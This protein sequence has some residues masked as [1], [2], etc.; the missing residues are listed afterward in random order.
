MSSLR[1]FVS[2]CQG[3]HNSNQIKYSPADFSNFVVSIIVT[4]TTAA[5]VIFAVNR[6][7]NKGEIYKMQNPDKKHQKR[8]SW[9]RKSLWY[10]VPANLNVECLLDCEEFA[11]LRCCTHVPRIK[12]KNSHKISS[13][14]FKEQCLHKDCPGLEIGIWTSVNQL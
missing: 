14:F 5:T 3:C 11:R 7:S 6:E 10:M 9:K 12:A 1:N 13:W 8:A 4:D 2:V